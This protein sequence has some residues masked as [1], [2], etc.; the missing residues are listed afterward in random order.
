M[1]D[2]DEIVDDI[3]SPD[4]VISERLVE[5]KELDEYEKTIEESLNLYNETIDKMLEESFDNAFDDAL[6]KILK[7]S[8]QEYEK[9]QKKIERGIKL[10]NII[11][12]ITKIQKYDNQNNILELILNIINKY[13][14]CDFEQYDIEPIDYNNILKEINKYRINQEE[15]SY[16]KKIFELIL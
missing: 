15:L 16:F 9:Q 2:I 12:T 10:N 8:E 7:D 11:N 3:R 14:N 6:N 4:H 13:I 1:D 5:N